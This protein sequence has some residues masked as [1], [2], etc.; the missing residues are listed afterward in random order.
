[1]SV[2]EENIAVA[3]AAG[4][5]YVSDEMPCIRRRRCGKGWQFIAPDGSTIT[6][7]DE[8][9]R[10]MALAIPPA[11]QDVWI[12]PNPRGHILATG[13]DDKGRKQYRYHDRWREVRDET[14][15]HKM[16]Q[17]GQMLPGMRK[18]I[19]GLLRQPG[20][21]R[22]KVLALVVRLLD[23]TLIRIG[24]DEYAEANDSY[25]LTTLRPEHVEVNGSTV[26]FEFTGKSGIEREIAL[27]DRRLAKLV[28][29]CHELGG[30]ELFGYRDADG[31]IVDI[32]SSD[33]NAFLRDLSGGDDVTAKDFRTW[34]GT[35]E[36][37]RALA[38]MGEPEDE[39]DLKKKVIAAVDRA[40][41]RLGNTRAVAR[42]SYV[43][44]AVPLSYEEGQLLE[45]WRRAR[46]AGT[47]DRGERTVLSVL[48]DRLE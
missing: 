2:I 3:E 20:L 16:A 13:R 45:R 32:G 15:F 41:Q 10:I 17:F 34:G 31:R 14:K 47:L 18:E 9:Q 21:P 5:E 8:R 11:W 28:H 40:A 46:T 19:D 23:D 44:P 22:E 1:V 33:V 6:N 48:Q 38:E 30:Q 42:S 39:K 35:V 43:H 37:A 12:C 25:G 27:K 29:Q 24:N 36:A 7:P 26:E 4:L